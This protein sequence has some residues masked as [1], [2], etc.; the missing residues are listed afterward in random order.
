M[1][2]HIADPAIAGQ[3]WLFTR[4]VSRCERAVA[5]LGNTV[6]TR[7]LVATYVSQ[8]ARD[9]TMPDRVY[10]ELQPGMPYSSYQLYLNP[11]SGLSVILDIFAPGQLAPI[12]NHCCWG[13]FACLEGEE[14]ERLYDVPADLSSPP[15]QIT[16]A[17]NK[18]GNVSVADADRHAFH[19][20]E[21]VGDEPAIS[22]HVYG[23]D[24]KRLERDRWDSHSESYV[25]FCSGSFAAPEQP[26]H[27]LTVIGLASV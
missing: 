12:H 10:R 22:L 6:S 9:W 15:L 21:C 4:F 19:Q 1:T 23:A 25:R 7:D 18:P 5:Q 17:C 20:V 27:Y 16:C 11:S 26:A 2:E 13:V 24:L 3:D 8:L 14:L